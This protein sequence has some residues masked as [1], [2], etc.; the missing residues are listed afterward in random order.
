MELI[1]QLRDMEHQFWTEGADFYQS[2]LTANCVM[3]FGELGIMDRQQIIDGIAGGRRWDEVSMGEVRLATIG[4]DAVV[5]VYR[6]RARR[7]D[8][9]Y[10]ALVSSVYAKQAG[11][12]KLAV[13]HQSQV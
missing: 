12:W 13:H 4:A 1:E 8:Q 3:L 11:E 2:H 9:D 6:A 5:L 10:S 7:G